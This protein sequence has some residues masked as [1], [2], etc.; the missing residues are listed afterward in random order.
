MT[1]TLVLRLVE[2]ALAN[3]ELR[4]EVEEVGSGERRHVRDCTELLAFALDL[5]SAAAAAGRPGPGESVGELQHSSTR[6][7]P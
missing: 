5:T 7:P 2:E 1:V 3:G 6:S 4:G